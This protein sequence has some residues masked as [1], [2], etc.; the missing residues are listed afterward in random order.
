VAP[1]EWQ[2]HT[3]LKDRLF[4]ECYSFSFFQAVHLLECLF[5][6]K[7][8][9]GQTLA[10][11][12]EVVRFSVRPGLSFPASD[13]A[14][15]EHVD[16]K[17]PVDMEVTFMGLIGP[18]GLL[19]HWLNELAMERLR[20]KDTSL[21]AFFDIFH[22][23]LISLFY[24]AWKKH[25]FPVN[26]LP[27]A[28]NRLSREL[29]SLIGLGTP[30]LSQTI[31][32]PEESLIFYSGLLS[33]PVP[34]AV[35]LEAT[36]EYFSGTSVQIEQFVDRVIPIDPEDQTQLGFAN[37]KLGSDA[38]C[39]SSAW[40]SQTKFRVN[41]GPMGYEQFVRFLP[42]GKMLQPV[43]SLVRYMVGIEYEFEV[44]LFLKR[45]EIPACALGMESPTSPRLG[46][47]TWVKS[48]GVVS[49]D[50]PYVSFQELQLRS[51]S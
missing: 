11:G 15:M 5:P 21:T 4:E 34:S 40:E 48:P 41:L 44:G 51:K 16:E 12:Q 19:P 32:L 28:R 30:G 45:E 14:Y 49:R 23:R 18:S 38:I 37:G 8:R 20:R 39:G 2:P 35:A 3:P 17:R 36:V 46:W 33:R 24:L 22:H 29:L 1:K 42:S 9:L 25:R 31:G 6:E 43:F 7:K 26:Y 10:P 27:G 13:I 47:S 50:D